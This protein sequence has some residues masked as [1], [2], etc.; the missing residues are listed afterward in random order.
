MIS[1]FFTF[2]S[3]FFTFHFSLS[4]LPVSIHKPFVCY[5]FLGTQW[6][7]EM[8]FLGTDGDLSTNSKLSAVGETRRSIVIYRSTIYLLH[9]FCGV[10]GVVGDDHC[11]VSAG[12]AVDHIDGIL[13]P[14]YQSEV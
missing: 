10:C 4:Y 11:R 8:E 5:Q 2:N 3:S 14:V 13:Y 7:T 1:F 12:L 6:P 9:K